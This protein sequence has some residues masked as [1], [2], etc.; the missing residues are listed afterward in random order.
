MRRTAPLLPA[1]WLLATCLALLVAGGQPLP[2]DLATAQVLGG[3]SP[4][5]GVLTQLGSAAVVLPVLALLCLL[6]GRTLGLRAA[7]PVAVLVAVQ[8]LEAV[9]TGPLV[10]AEPMGLGTVSS[11]QT[12]TA[13][14]G[15]GLC[16]LQ[17]PALRSRALLVGAGVGA[18]VGLSRVGL[19]QHW[20]SDVLVG[21]LL[22]FLALQV[23]QACLPTRAAVRAPRVASIPAGGSRLLLWARTSPW[24]W[25][26]PA[27]AVL[28]PMV[29]WLLVPTADRMIDFAVYAGAG[30][31]AGDG[32]QVYR[33]R[34]DPGL[35]FTY[36]P[37]AAVLSE[38][39]SRVPL[40]LVQ[41]GWT[42]ATLAALVGVARVAMRP[43]VDRL[44]L[45]VVLA[46]L[47]VSSPVRSHLHFG[48][49]GLFLV[50]VVSL[51][52]LRPASRVRGWGLGLAAAV[53]LTPAVFLPW[54]VVTRSWGRLAGT[55]AVASGATLLGLLV[56]WP[57][58]GDYLLHALWDTSR[59]GSNAW[60]GNQSVRGALLRSGVPSAELLWLGSVLVLVVV[61]TVGAAR[62]ERSGNR[63]AAV[64]VLAAMSVAVSPISWVHHLVWLVL[65]LAALVA[66]DRGRIAAAW[67]LLLVVPLPSVAKHLPDG[68]FTALVMDVQGLTAV[69]AV[70]LVPRL[71]RARTPVRSEA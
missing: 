18:V 1:A 47:L 62:L 70:L 27:A 46:L 5:A 53:K 36:P 51:D 25:L 24:A 16:A 66:A 59:F 20:G 32:G 7:A 44:G 21:G 49:V 64:G 31:V 40:L 37:L 19:A 39:L 6:R 65:P 14:L 3:L 17:V 33:F 30:Q 43:V 35:P 15:W 45:P 50:L 12:L 22:G 10:R 4:T 71:V 57:S 60:P 63:L 54:L 67:T 28:V 26:L 23:A 2:G 48:Q 8:G 34:T 42:L 11:G 56:L 52:L 9:L 41:L 55:V 29:P 61:G 69:A 58:S 38:P 13:V 68:A